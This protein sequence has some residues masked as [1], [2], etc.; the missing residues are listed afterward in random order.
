MTIDIISTLKHTQEKTEPTERKQRAE[1]KLS[2]YVPNHAAA[3]FRYDVVDVK[4]GKVSVQTKGSAGPDE[5]REKLENDLSEI[6]KGSVSEQRKGSG[7]GPDLSF[8]NPF[9]RK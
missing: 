6:R 5:E 1:R 2:D 3:Q 8:V 7:S 9:K 4:L